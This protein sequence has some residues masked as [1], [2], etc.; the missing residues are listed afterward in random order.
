MADPRIAADLVGLEGSWKLLVAETP[1]LAVSANAGVRQARADVLLILDL[2]R[3]Y[4]P[5]DLARV[6]APVER[7]LAELAVGCHAETGLLGRSVRALVGTSDPRSGLVAL[8]RSCVEQA[9]EPLEPI[10]SRYVIDLLLKTRKRNL[11][12][13]VRA[14]PVDALRGVRLDDL[15]RLKRLADRISA[16][17]RALLQ[18]CMVGASGMLVDLSSYALFQQLFSRTWLA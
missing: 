10:H 17:R 15:R 18:F 13:P 16:M 5:E 3:G 14:A 12:V 7:G 2:E 1:G 4:R 6:I 11:D 9:G 8:S